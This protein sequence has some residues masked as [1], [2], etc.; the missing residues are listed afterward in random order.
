MRAALTFY[1]LLLY[2]FPAP[3]RARFGGDME[4]VFADRIRAAG[5]RGPLAVGACVLRASAD[6]VVQG[7]RERRAERVA[8][9]ARRARG[10]VAR[11]VAFGWRMLCRHP[12]FATAAVVTLALGIGANVATF[13]A[14]RAVLINSLPYAEP[15]RLVY[16]S[17]VIPRALGPSFTFEDFATIREHASAFAG[18]AGCSFDH[19]VVRGDGDPDTRRSAPSRRIS[20]ASSVRHRSP[21]A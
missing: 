7:T 12:G 21:A 11:D 19:R 8:R 4:D 15:D 3:F 18:V 16:M 17:P 2:A 13:S 5:Q 1:R 6:V 9:Q 10:S 20:S 14:V